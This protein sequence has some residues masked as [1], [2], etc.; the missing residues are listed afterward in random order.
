VHFVSVFDNKQEVSTI[1]L[2][3]FG[4]TENRLETHLHKTWLLLV[5]HIYEY[6]QPTGFIYFYLVV[7]FLN[8]V[9]NRSDYNNK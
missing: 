9:L 2:I 3:L 7:V 4:V 1:V 8:H 6:L 5:G